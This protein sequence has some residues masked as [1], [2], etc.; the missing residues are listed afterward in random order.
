MLPNLQLT[1][2]AIG[3]YARVEAAHRRVGTALGEFDVRIAAQDIANGFTPMAHKPECFDLIPN[4]KPEGCTTCNRSP[5]GLRPT[6]SATR[7]SIQ[8]RTTHWTLDTEGIITPNEL[9][10]IISVGEL[11]SQG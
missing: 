4:L 2:A 3:I 7:A 1:E 6:G 5:P 10:A 8:T 9:S 11:I